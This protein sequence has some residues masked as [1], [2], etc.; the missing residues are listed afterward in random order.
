[1]G[2]HTSPPYQGKAILSQKEKVM[3]LEITRNRERALTVETGLVTESQKNRLINELHAE[4]NQRRRNQHKINRI[5]ANVKRELKRIIHRHRCSQR[6]IGFRSKNLNGID[7]TNFDEREESDIEWRIRQIFSPLLQKL[8]IYRSSRC[9]IPPDL[10]STLFKGGTTDLS[11]ID[12]FVCPPAPPLVGVELNPGP[13]TGR[14]PRKRNKRKRKTHTGKS[15]KNMID[16]EID[17]M[18]PEKYIDSI[19]TSPTAVTTSGVI[20]A[21][22]NVAQ[23]TQDGQRIADAIKVMSLTIGTLEVY[24]F[25]SDLV[26]HLRMIIFQWLPNIADYAPTIADILETPTTNSCFS[27]LNVEHSPEYIKLYDRLWSFVGSGTVLTTASD[28]VIKNRRIK[29]PPKPIVYESTSSSGSSGTVCLL[30]ISDSAS[31]PNPAINYAFR[32]Y[33]KD[34]TSTGASGARRRLVA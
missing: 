15:L 25:N 30:L 21:L 14:R 29:R 34:T 8:R 18:A 2:Q 13:Q 16:K 3:Q 17:R 9:S 24:A 20:G 19:T 4:L 11:S 12:Y 10:I 22:F 5:T 23:G 31:T 1:M 27:L 33:Y 28:H 6:L 7:K 26:S 32:T